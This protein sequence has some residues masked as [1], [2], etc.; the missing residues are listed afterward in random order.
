MGARSLI[1][2]S[3]TLAT[4][5][6]GYKNHVIYIIKYVYI[7]NNMADS[8]PLSV[9]IESVGKISFLKKL[10]LLSSVVKLA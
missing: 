8:W 10:T 2:R 7:S 4:V 6:Y 9:N 1:D 5:I 3:D